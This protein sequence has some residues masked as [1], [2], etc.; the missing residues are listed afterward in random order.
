MK[1]KILVTK[2]D[3]QH[4]V[5]PGKYRVE[6]PIGPIEARGA[7]HVLLYGVAPMG[8]P[9]RWVLAGTERT[10][11]YLPGSAPAPTHPQVAIQPS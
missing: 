1:L 7:A 2:H 9:V 5:C 8:D 6:R 11:P 4:L 3:F 10:L